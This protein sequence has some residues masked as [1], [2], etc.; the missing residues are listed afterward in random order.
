[1]LNIEKLTSQVEEIMRL[2]TSSC[3]KILMGFR[4]FSVI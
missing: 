4:I 1:V 3:G 2:W